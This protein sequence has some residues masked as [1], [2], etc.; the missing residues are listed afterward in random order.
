MV[1]SSSSLCKEQTKWKANLQSIMHGLYVR[2][3]IPEPGDPERE[4][5]VVETFQEQTDDELT[6]K[7]V[8]Q[9]EDD[10]QAIQIILMGLPKDIYAVVD[11]YDFKR[12]KH[13]PEKIASNLKFLNN[14]QPEWRRR[15]TIVHQS[16][17]LYEVDYT[18]LYDFLK[19]NQVEVNELRAKRLASAHDPLALMANYNNPYNYPV[20]HQDQPSQVTYMQQPQPNNNYVPQPSFSQNYM[21]QPMLNP[22]DI[23]DPTT[24]INMALV[25]MT[26][27][28]KLNYST[29]TNNNQIISSNPR[30][31]QIA[32]P[33]QNVKN[34]VVHNAVQNRCVQNVGNQNGLIIVSGIAN[35]IVNQ[36][37]NGNVVA[38]RAEGNGNG[39]GNNEYQVRCYNC[40][41][42]GHLARNCTVR[43]RRRDAA[44]L[45]KL[46][47]LD[48][49]E[50]VNANYILMAN[51]QQ[52]STSGTQTNSSPVYDSDGSAKLLEPITKPHLVQQ[53]NSN[54]I[55]VESSVEHSGG[56]VEQYPATVEETL[57]YFESLYNSLAIEV[58]KVNTVNHNLKA[59][60]AD[61]TTELVRYKG[62]EKATKFVRDFK[63]LA[64]EADESFAKHKAL[65][66]EIERLLRVVLQAQLGDLKGQSIDTQC[67]SNTLDPLSQKLD[68]ENVSLEFQDLG[69]FDQLDTA[70]VVSRIRR[71]RN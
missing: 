31:R 70:Y 33:V 27:A 37:G 32:Q 60:N 59:T 61:F 5:P 50:E 24:A 26:K 67:A 64:K 3:I 16:K 17:D 15:V 48:E 68:D 20:F 11:S 4:V 14:Q 62:Q 29:L 2:Q 52:A 23:S 8:N 18:Q 58:E 35:Q 53:N 63:S 40:K 41:G 71:I 69:L 54:V 7:E 13:F 56:T 39:N 42:M 47:D 19:Y 28:F 1:F 46:R 44:Y 49:I 12:N 66:Y 45:F 43:P 10:D 57:A 51:L 55:L 25:L 34:Q 30:N 21:Q 38:T 36:N 22:E 65:E 6:N 9:M